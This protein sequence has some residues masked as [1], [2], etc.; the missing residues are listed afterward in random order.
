M[1]CNWLHS[2]VRGSRDMHVHRS[3]RLLMNDEES[4]RCHIPSLN[5]NCYLRLLLLLL[6]PRLLL[7]LLL[8]PPFIRRTSQPSNIQLPKAKPIWSRRPPRKQVLHG[9][10]YTA[11][12]AYGLTGPSPR[13]CR[14]G[15]PR[16]DNLSQN[17]S[18]RVWG[19]GGLEFRWL[20]V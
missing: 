12:C 10:H 15:S 7:L 11:V 5:T 14:P 20:G 1:C 17:L 13:G 18:H 4:K 19:L 6:R 16:G 9:A 8:H 2:S 3:F